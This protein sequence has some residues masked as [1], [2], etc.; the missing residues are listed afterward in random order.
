MQKHLNT[1]VADGMFDWY[2]SLFESLSSTLTS[3][4]KSLIHNSIYN[5]LIEP[6][7]NY[8]N[9]IGELAT[10]NEIKK[11]FK[12]DLISV[13]E[14]IQ[15]ENNFT[16]DFLFSGKDGNTNVLV[17]V[18]NL[19]FQEMNIE[20]DENIRLRIES[21]LKNKIEVKFTNPRYEYLLQPVIWTKDLNDIKYLFN[22]YAETGLP[23][24]NVLAPFTYFT[25]KDISGQYEH[26]FDR[27]Y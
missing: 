7:K 12:C 15:N 20:K 24:N 25:F 17:E 2:C 5:L 4:E 22:L 1:G 19:H 3:F 6:D 13:E 10:L 27:I 8:L 23:I 9:F 18:V 11:Q 16:A 14:P 26:H 21:K